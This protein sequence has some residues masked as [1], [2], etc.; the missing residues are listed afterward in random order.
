MIRRWRIRFEVTDIVEIGDLT[1]AEL[2]PSPKMMIFDAPEKLNQIHRELD[3][4]FLNELYIAT[5]KEYL[6][7]MM[8]KGVSK[9]NTLNATRKVWESA[10]KRLWPVV[11]ILMIWKW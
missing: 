9:K 10:E 4:L 8:P 3:Q 11:I 1:K 6:L 2:F 5:S 7:E